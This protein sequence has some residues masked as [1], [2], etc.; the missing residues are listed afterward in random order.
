[1]NPPCAR[2]QKTV[3]PTE[4][5]N[6]LDKPWH[7]GCFKCQ[8]CGL[9]LNL[10]TYKGYKKLPYCN[11]HYPKTGFTTI[12]DTPENMRLKQNT[13]NQSAVVYQ[14]D[15]LNEKSKFTAVADDPETERNRKMQQQASVT[16][17]KG[18]AP[19]GS[20]EATS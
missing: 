10:K 7:K 11:S 19:P 9:T 13:T 8:E 12:V 4:R 5:L 16:A 1:M 20:R 3:Y 6:C 14:K 17:Y 18:T 2:C 15:H